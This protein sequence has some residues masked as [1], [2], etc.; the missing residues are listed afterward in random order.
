[1]C[2]FGSRCVWPNCIDSSNAFD[3]HLRSRAPVMPL[4]THDGTIIGE[5]PAGS[6]TVEVRESA[7]LV[8]LK[9][10]ALL[11]FQA[12]AIAKTDLKELPVTAPQQH[13]YAN[14]SNRM[15]M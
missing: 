11:S 3:C 6:F 2:V 10:D 5:V 13:V 12:L 14:A 7:L 9:E 8:T 4:Q 15:Q 1:M